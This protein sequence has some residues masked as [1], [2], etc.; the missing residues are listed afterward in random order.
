[1]TRRLL[2]L[3]LALLTAVLICTACN[4][5]PHEPEKPVTTGF[6]CDVDM[7]YQDM[8]IKGRLTRESAGTLQLAFSEPASLEGMSMQWD[9]ETV[10]MKMGGISFGVDP[11]DIPQ[12]ALGKGLLDALDAGFRSGGDGQVTEK[13]LATTGDSV[14][15]QFEILSDPESGQLLSMRIP[16][17]NIAASFSNFKTLGES[18]NE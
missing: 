17:L 16:E 1:M 11:A 3:C 12:S 10:T 2:G 8:R 6:A 14:N 4:S 18:E 5:S 7:T 15:G 13:G 9:G